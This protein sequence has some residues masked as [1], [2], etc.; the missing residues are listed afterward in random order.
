M[1]HLIRGHGEWRGTVS[2]GYGSQGP[3]QDPWSGCAPRRRPGRGAQ[4]DLGSPR[5]CWATKLRIISRLTGAMRSRRAMPHRSASPYSVDMPLPPWVWM[6]WSGAAR[7]ASAAA[8]FAMLAASPAAAVSP[9]KS[10]SQAA[11]SVIS[12]ASSTLILAVANGWEIPWWRPMGVPHTSRVLAYSAALPSCLLYTS[13]SPRD[14][15][16]S[17]M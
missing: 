6:A 2:P 14:G 17:R 3:R 5:E 8:Y 1:N 13:P 15:L 4:Y 11:L 7:V 10:H 16:L 9:A 12:R